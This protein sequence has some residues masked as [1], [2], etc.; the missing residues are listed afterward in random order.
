MLLLGIAGAHQRD[1]P[2]G[3]L[4]VGGPDLLA[5]HF[6]PA[7]DA[8]RARAH[9]GE[10][11]ARA[12]LAHADAEAELAARDRGQKRLALL[13]RAEAQQQ[14]PAL[15]VGDPMRTDRRAGDQQF[16]DHDI[17]FGIR[18]L[19]AAIRLGPGHPDPAARA[20]LPAELAAAARPGPRAFDRR[21]IRQ[22]ISEERAHLA[23]KR[24][25]LRR[26]FER[27]KIEARQWS[28]PGAHCGRRG[29]VAQ[30]APQTRVERTRLRSGAVRGA[31]AA[32]RRNGPVRWLRGLVPRNRLRLLRAVMSTPC[33]I[34]CRDSSPRDSESLRTG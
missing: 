2:V 4:R 9:G 26:K 27:R 19:V 31:A 12:R 16:L 32:M 10:I 6:P 17:A 15:P 14:R 7:V 33:P 28:L 1:H 25:R 21:L 5:R 3:V 20:Q 13:F 8:T 29:S 18:A 24:S 34:P 22:R 11:G 30:I 23:A